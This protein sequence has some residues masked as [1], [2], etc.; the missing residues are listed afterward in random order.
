VQRDREDDKDEFHW[1]ISGCPICCAWVPSD[2]CLRVISPMLNTPALT[3]NVAEG[4]MQ[5]GVMT[6]TMKPEGFLGV[7]N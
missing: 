6:G 7:K 3:L 4:S 1:F 5:G 2:G